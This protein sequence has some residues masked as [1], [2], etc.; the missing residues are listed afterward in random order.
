MAQQRD[1]ERTREKI[2]A[3]AAAEFAAKGLAGARV[4]AIARRAR[5]NKQMLYYCFGAKRELY[6]EVLRRKFA[7]RASFLESMPDDIEGA[8]LHIYDHGGRDSDFVR[9]LE[10]EALEPGAGRRIATRERRALFATAM[11]KFGR[12]QQRGIIPRDV[13]PCHLFISFIACAV[14]PLAFPQMIEM[15]TGLDPASA[16]FVRGRREFLRWLGRRLSSP[17]AAEGPVPH[18]T[19]ASTPANG[20]PPHEVA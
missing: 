17:P 19:P 10:W 8:L 13:D 7:D 14:F 3:A 6:R 20:S 1:L 16:R 5:I 9:M 15:V 2:L 11:H 4:D 12:A 18:P